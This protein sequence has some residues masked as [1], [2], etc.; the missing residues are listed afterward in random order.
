MDLD[1]ALARVSTLEYPPP[2]RFVSHAPMACEV[3]DVLGR[4]A[5]LDAWVESSEAHLQRER[6]PAPSVW[7]PGFDWQAELGRSEVLPQWM[8]YFS[9]SIER[10]GWSDTV[11][12]WV[13]RLMPGLSA[14]LFH[15][16]IRT[17]HAVRGVTRAETPERRD[18]L[19]RALAHWAVWFRPGETVASTAEQG[20]PRRA[21]L[22]A[23]A[24]GVGCFIGEPTILNL[25][26]VTGAMAVHLLSG[27]LSEDDARVA[28]AQLLA[29]HRALYGNEAHQFDPEEHAVWDDATIDAAVESFDP[30]QL[31]LVEACRRGF[32]LSGDARFAEGARVVTHL[33]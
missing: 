29:E 23:A 3:L 15:G 6:P 5:S 28:T 33:T 24:H 26:G 11:S 17:S 16:V 12:A 13:P 30:H 21:A 4:A 7:G 25:H 31:K 14:A 22:D 20:D 19:A 8:G 10:D 32:T 18:E 2:K 27:H 9:E 1:G